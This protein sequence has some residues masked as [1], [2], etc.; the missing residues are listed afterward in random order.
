MLK[1]I[2]IIVCI[3]I[4][5]AKAQSDTT[6][7]TIMKKENYKTPLEIL[8][9]SSKDTTNHTNK[10]PTSEDIYTPEQDSAFY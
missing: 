8:K 5:C 4:T 7:N 2:F 6:A 1:Y 10:L 3:S 9:E